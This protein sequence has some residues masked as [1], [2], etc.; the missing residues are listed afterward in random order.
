MTYLSFRSELIDIMADGEHHDVRVDPVSLRRVI[1][2]IDCMCPY[3]GAE[4][5]RQI[6]DPLFQG[7]DWL[8]VR[9]LIHSAP[10]VVRPG[11]VD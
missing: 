7:V 5:I 9:P 2:W 4:E 1:A 3:Q 10:T 6:P 11:P 8:S